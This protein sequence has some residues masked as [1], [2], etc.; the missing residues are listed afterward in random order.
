M[1]MRARALPIIAATPSWNRLTRRT[2]V[3]PA[4]RAGRELLSGMPS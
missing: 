1:T 4:R 3:L 2:V